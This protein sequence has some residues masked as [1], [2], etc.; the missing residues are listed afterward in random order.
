MS[1]LFR[2]CSSLDILL[3]GKAGGNGRSQPGSWG[4]RY[5][6]D[7]SV[8]KSVYGAC[9]SPSD[10][11]MALSGYHLWAEGAL[12]TGKLQGIFGRA[13]MRSTSQESVTISS[14]V[15]LKETE[16]AIHGNAATRITKSLGP[17]HPRTR[18]LS[19]KRRGRQCRRR[20]G[21]L[22]PMRSMLDPNFAAGRMRRWLR[23]YRRGWVWG[24]SDNPTMPSSE[25]SPQD[26]KAV[27]LDIALLPQAHKELASFMSTRGG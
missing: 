27:E 22:R 26:R 19:P 7:G 14:L 12:M 24:W 18:A 13:K 17:L 25:Q 16:E 21:C 2:D 5:V 20:R 8:R 11:S 3:Q 6:L 15:K 9:A 4:V 10:S 23:P 1:G